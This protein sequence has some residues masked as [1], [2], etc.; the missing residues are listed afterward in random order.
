MQKLQQFKIT[1]QAGKE[2]KK[3]PIGKVRNIIDSAAEYNI[4]ESE[5]LS[6]KELNIS[7]EKKSIRIFNVWEEIVE[8]KQTPKKPQAKK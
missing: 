4:Q 3:E 8:K 5:I 2:V 7:K 6:E 1:L